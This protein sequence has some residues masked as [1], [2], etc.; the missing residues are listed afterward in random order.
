MRVRWTSP[1][2]FLPWLGFSYYVVWALLSPSAVSSLSALIPLQVSSLHICFH[3]FSIT[4]PKLNQNR[5]LSS[6]LG[7][8]TPS[9]LSSTRGQHLVLGVVLEDRKKKKKNLHL[10]KNKNMQ[11]YISQ[12]QMATKVDKP[13]KTLPPF[14]NDW[15]E[16]SLLVYYNT[17][18]CPRC[19]SLSHQ[20]SSACTL[21]RTTV[22]NQYNSTTKER[23][24]LDWM[25]PQK[26]T[27]W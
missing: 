24:N 1:L 5:C 27:C 25:L 14:P 23:Y 19:A 15:K 4:E 3:L 9:T 22:R 20:K 13:T 16:F 7:C 10:Q 11:R 17:E 12:G 6:L 18:L 26:Q 8:E 2:P 21:K